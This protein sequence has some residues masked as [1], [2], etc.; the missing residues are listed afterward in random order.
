LAA[1]HKIDFSTFRISDEM[2]AKSSS[3][4]LRQRSTP[5]KRRDW[6]EFYLEDT[7]RFTRGEIDKLLKGKVFEK[8]EDYARPTLF[9]MK[10][11]R[12]Y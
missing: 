9:V 10:K 1:K 2:L 4:A 6:V 3:R 11:P 5:K 12:Q 8:I 7:P